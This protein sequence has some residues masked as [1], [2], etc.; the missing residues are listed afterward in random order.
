MMKQYDCGLKHLL[1]ESADLLEILYGDN[2]STNLKECDSLFNGTV[3]SLTREQTLE[4]VHQ[5]LGC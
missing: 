5:V 2:L 3:I 1:E 4:S